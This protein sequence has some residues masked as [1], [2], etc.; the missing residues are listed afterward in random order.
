MLSDI[1]FVLAATIGIPILT[2][3]MVPIAVAIERMFE[4]CFPWRG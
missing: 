3:A 4:R 1:E 2:L